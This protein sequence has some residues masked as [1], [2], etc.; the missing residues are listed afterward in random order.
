MSRLIERYIEDLFND[1]NVS[2]VNRKALWEYYNDKLSKA[3]DVGWNNGFEI[4][5][6]ELVDSL[7][8]SIAEFSAFKETSFKK[9]LEELLTKDG[10]LTP[11]NE[12]LKDAYKVSG[13]YNHRWLQTE[14]HETIAGANMA[15]KMKDYE[16]NIDLYPNLKLV[17]V[18]DARVR[19]EHKVLNGTIRPFNDPFWNDHTPPLDWGCRCDLEQT[20][21]EVTEVKGGIQTKIEFANNPAKTGKIFGGSAYEENLNDEEIKEAKANTEKWTK[22]KDYE[23]LHKSAIFKSNLEDLSEEMKNIYP[24]IDVEKINSINMYSGYYYGEIN[25]FN[26]GLIRKVEIL[27]EHGITEDFYSKL[28]KTINKGLDEIPDKYVGTTYRGTELTRE[29]MKPYMNAWKS[30]N[31][32]IEETFMSS[33]YSK[34]EAFS[35]NVNFEIVSKTGTKI[36]KISEKPFE[37]EVLF[38]AGQKFKVTNIKEYDG[39]VWHV[40]LEEI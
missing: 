19:P 40:F 38:K 33:S 35:G 15:A 1:K 4:D 3:V 18:R 5:D 14:Y 39:D 16:Q 32:H 2:F 34:S 27:P 28:T 7:K 17:S 13:D 30:G 36:E 26:R 11:K 24:D 29:Q 22:Q 21:E 6:K 8:N 23:T 37:K 10:K 20:D 31:A 25:N 12:F 9:N